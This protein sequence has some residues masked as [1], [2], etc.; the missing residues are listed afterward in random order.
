MNES[1][2]LLKT[3]LEDR[4]T[5]IEAA[6]E[7]NAPALWRRVRSER[8]ARLEA[9]LARVAGAP[10][11]LLLL[12]GAAALLWGSGLHVSLPCWAI[13]FWLAFNGALVAPPRAVRAT[14]TA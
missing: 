14:L 4:R 9:R 5:L 7:P 12:A 6:P 1:D 2:R 11:A 10:P 8:Q 13:A 3:I